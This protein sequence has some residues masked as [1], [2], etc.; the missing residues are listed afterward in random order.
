MMAESNPL[1][2]IDESWS[3]VA[4][5]IQRGMIALG[6]TRRFGRRPALSA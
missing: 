1:V 3:S 2:M 5:L 4:G 6:Q